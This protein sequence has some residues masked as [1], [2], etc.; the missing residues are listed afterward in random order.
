MWLSN[1]DV[2]KKLGT[3]NVYYLIVKE[4]K[5]KFKT[6]NLTKQQIREY[7]T[8][9]KLIVYERFMYTNEDIIIYIIMKCG[10]STPEAIECRSRIG[11]MQHGVIVT[12]EQ[13]VISKIAKLFA[14]EKI[15]PQHT[16]LD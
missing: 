8:G 2:R 7:M 6:T 5:C 9:L 13:P 1:K 11:F 10:V 14:K 4:T 3:K 12:K 15:P 16:V